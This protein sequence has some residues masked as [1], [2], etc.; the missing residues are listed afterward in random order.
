M[1][2]IWIVTYPNPN[3]TL[4]DVV[5][6]ADGARLELQFKGGLLGEDIYGFFCSRIEAESAAEQLL[7]VRDK[8]IGA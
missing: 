1:R 6:E 5:F 2:T 7:K 8:G 4:V 3:S